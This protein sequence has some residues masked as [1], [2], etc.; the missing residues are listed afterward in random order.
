VTGAASVIAERV[1]RKHYRIAATD[2]APRSDFRSS[3]VMYRPRYER[4]ARRLARDLGIKRVSPLDGLRAGR[5]QGAHL[6][7]I[8]GG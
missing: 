8:V 2:D 5:L 1:R 4:E 6:A 7:Y 3:L